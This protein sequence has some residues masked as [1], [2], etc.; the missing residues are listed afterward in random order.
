LSSVTAV[1]DPGVDAVRVTVDLSDVAGPPASA[2]VYRDA[3]SAVVVRNGD[4]AQLTSGQTFLTDY[5]APRDT[6]LRYRAVS[7]ATVV[8][9]DT[10]M[11]PSGG[12]VKLVHPGKPSLSV[13]LGIADESAVDL[14]PQTVILR[15]LGRDDAISISSGLGAESASFTAYTLSTED[16]LSLK[17]VLKDGSPLFLAAPPSW[18]DQGY[19][20][21]TGVKLARVQAKRP[22]EQSRLWT[23]DYTR[24]GRPSGLGASEYTYADVLNTYATYADVLAVETSYFDVLDGPG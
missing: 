10:V 17:S 9:S 15:P 21:F 24:V 22:T 14:D 16:A 11:H 12:R 6:T 23:F 4:P 20:N 8:V 1:Y 13:G 18:I 5:E 3:V 7:G 19:V 2:T